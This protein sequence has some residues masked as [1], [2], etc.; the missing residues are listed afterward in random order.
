M[1]ISIIL[2]IRSNMKDREQALHH[3]AVHR[4][5]F[6]CVQGLRQLPDSHLAEI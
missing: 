2:E 6:P 1:A 3:P 5:P 4:L